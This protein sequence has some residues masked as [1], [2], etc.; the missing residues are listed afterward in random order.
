[1]PDWLCIHR[2]GGFSPCMHSRVGS[3][4]T[5]GHVSVSW[6]HVTLL[7]HIGHRPD[8][9]RCALPVAVV[10]QGANGDVALL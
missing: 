4:L 1:M 5:Y 3:L 8:K 7:L 10:E 2:P 9:A 6:H